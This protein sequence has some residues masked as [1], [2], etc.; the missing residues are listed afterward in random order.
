MNNSLVYTDDQKIKEGF[1][2]Q[3]MIVLPPSIRRTIVGNELIKRLYVTAIGFYPCARHHNKVRK[4]GSNQYILLYC[5]NG[6]GSI[7]LQDRE[8]SLSPN[9]F[10]IIPKQVAYQYK[11][12]DT[13][14]WS[15]YWVHFVGDH[16][17]ILYHRCL[18][19]EKETPIPHLE[20]RFKLFNEI[21]SILNGG[22]Q[23]REMEIANIKFF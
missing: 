4:L 5:I 8:I 6:Q 14:P 18:E 9:T 11:S 13:D 23:M 7:L 20:K 15:I 22:F 3:E 2:G 17:D 1:A 10:F 16:A 21:L 12:S 19:K